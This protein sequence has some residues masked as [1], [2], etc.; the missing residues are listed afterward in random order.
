MADPGEDS[1]TPDGV[2]SGVD[3]ADLSPWFNPFLPHFAR[4]ARRCGGE[5]RVAR[6]GESLRALL[7][8]DP[9]E[10]VATVFTRSLPRA[11]DW[12]RDRGAYGMY[13]DFPF[14]PTDEEFAIFARDFGPEPPSQRFRHPVRPVSPSDLPAVRDLMVEVYGLVNDR[15]FGGVPNEVETG[16]ACE[17]HGRLA[18]VAWVTRAGRHA[19]LHSLTVRPP[20]RRMGLGSDLLSARLLWAHR[21]GAR[22]VLSEISVHNAASQA[23]AV[24]DGMRKVGSIYFHTPR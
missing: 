11:Q 15:W 1:T 14:E 18:G 5:V 2:P 22:R 9:V 24:R 20:F 23:I 13:S 12:V 4:E 16:F 17:V 19:R 21:I 8:S 10:R 7:V 6:E 3:E